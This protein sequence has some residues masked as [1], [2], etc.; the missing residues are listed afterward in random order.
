[1]TK[2]GQLLPGDLIRVICSNNGWTLAYDPSKGATLAEC[3]K[4]TQMY[5][6]NIEGKLGLV[7][8]I[9]TNKLEQPMAYHLEIEKEK[10][11]CKAI[12]ADKYL[13]KI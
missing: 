11:V 3:H 6:N 12:L 2:A 7:I 10:Y 1:M 9:K 13:L 4:R 8:R 5:N